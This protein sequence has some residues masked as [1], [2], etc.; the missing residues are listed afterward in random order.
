MR[1]GSYEIL[2]ALG[3]GG[4]GEVYRARD[5]KLNRDVAMKVL[6]RDL[7]FSADEAEHLLI[8]ADL[9]IQL[10]KVIASR[11]S[12]RRRLPKSCGSRS[13]AS[14]TCCEGESIS[15]APT[16]SLTCWRASGSKSVSS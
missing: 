15:S 9:L 8:R 5:T 6:F 14:A 10:Q 7:G 1:I 12:R 16:A 11:A 3:A 2:A 13:L 4:M